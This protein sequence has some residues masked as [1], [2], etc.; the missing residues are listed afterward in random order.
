MQLLQ[1]IKVK[2]KNQEEIRVVMMTMMNTSIT[3]KTKKRLEKAVIMMMMNS[4][5][6]WSR[7]IVKNNLKAEV[8]KVPILEWEVA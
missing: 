5:R 2:N 1:S 6:K 4:N 8:L 3:M 7:C